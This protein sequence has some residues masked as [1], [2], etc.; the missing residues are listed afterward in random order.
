MHAEPDR[1]TASMSMSKRVGKIFLDWLR[2]Q[3]GATAVMPYT[4]R[5]RAKAPVSVP[6][7]WTELEDLDTAA[8]WHVGDQDELLAR[9]SSK[10]L[11]GWGVARQVLPDL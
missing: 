7:T 11:A 9:A 10:S 8:Q 2:N 4:A 1:F 6:V 5:A 3:R